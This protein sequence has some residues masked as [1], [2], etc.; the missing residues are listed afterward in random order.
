MLVGCCK[1]HPVQWGGGGGKG[2]GL[3]EGRVGEGKGGR[4]EMIEGECWYM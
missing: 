3:R 4:G 2:G 1:L